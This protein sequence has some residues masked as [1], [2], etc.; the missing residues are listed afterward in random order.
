MAGLATS[1]VVSPLLSLVKEKAF[2]Y[3]Q[4]MEGME[5]Q[6]EVLKRKLPAILDVITDAEEQA[7]YRE[8]VRAWLGKLK[9]VAYEVIDI[10]DEFEYEA[11]RRQAK[12]NGHITKFGIMT[13][14]MLFPTHNRLVF[15]IRMGSKLQRLVNTINVLLDE[16]N[17]F[18]FNT[19]Q[20]QA[21]ALKEWRE[22]ASIIDGPEDIVSRSR[23]E[24][25]KKIV[26]ILV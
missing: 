8:G 22:T 25:R 2:N 1:L 13:G 9:A 12:K 11:L 21:P 15:R 16:M 26:E 5:K 17:N 20:R 19:I 4:V 23:Y 18:G 3:L 24:E 10:F 6:H 14:V 7:S